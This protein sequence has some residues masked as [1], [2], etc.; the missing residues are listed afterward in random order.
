MTKILVCAE[1]RKKNALDKAVAIH[2]VDS[3]ALNAKPMDVFGA[4]N[5]RHVHPLAAMI[6][7]AL[8]ILLL[9]GPI[10]TALLFSAREI[11]LRTSHV[12][13]AAATI[14]AK[15]LS[16]PVATERLVFLAIHA[17]MPS[18]KQ[19]VPASAFGARPCPSVKNQLSAHVFSLLQSTIIV[20]FLTSHL[21]AMQPKTANGAKL[22]LGAN[23][24]TRPVASNVVRLESSSIMTL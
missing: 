15:N 19:P 20:N 22:S 6:P 17:K 16:F 2:V 21:N 14:C 10:A 3:L 23:F 12:G 7:T 5:R 9:S 1:V 4:K 8:Q 11:V 24:R 13:G 18:L